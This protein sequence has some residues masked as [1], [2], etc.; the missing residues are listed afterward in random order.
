MR[1]VNEKGTAMST[2]MVTATMTTQ[3]RKTR[4][5]VPKWEREKKIFT[6]WISIFIYCLYFG[7]LF[8]YSLFCRF[9]VFLL[10]L[11]GF[12]FLF[13]FYPYCNLNFRRNLILKLDLFLL[14]AI[15]KRIIDKV[16]FLLFLCV[17]VFMCCLI[18]IISLHF[19]KRLRQ[20]FFL[21]TFKS[22]NNM[23]TDLFCCFFFLSFFPLCVKWHKSCCLLYNIATRKRIHTYR[24]KQHT[25]VHKYTQKSTRSQ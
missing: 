24:Y 16:F 9:N 17:R 11:F 10:S 25:R 1:R 20:I 4:T 13:N 18:Q 21:K 5:P 14:L 19:N 8:P 6:Q 12:F 22:N 23:K 2:A 15:F 3:K 7:D